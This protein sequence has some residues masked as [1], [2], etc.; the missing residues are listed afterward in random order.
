MVPTPIRTLVSLKYSSCGL[1]SLCFLQCCQQACCCF[2]TKFK[3]QV[4]AKHGHVDKCIQTGGSP[5]FGWS[6]RPGIVHG[7]SAL[8]F[9]GCIAEPEL[10]SWSETILWHLFQDWLIVLWTSTFHVLFTTRIF[11][12]QVWCPIVFAS[13]GHC[14]HLNVGLQNTLSSEAL[15]KGLTFVP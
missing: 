14:F 7:Q 13:S 8:C 5:C 2:P 12:L 6:D 11:I 10:T 15:K 1:V 4:T 9:L 3:S